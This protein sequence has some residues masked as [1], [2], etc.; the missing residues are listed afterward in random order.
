MRLNGHHFCTHLFLHVGTLH[1]G[2]GD[3]QGCQLPLCAVKGSRKRWL[4]KWRPLRFHCLLAPN[5]WIRYWTQFCGGNLAV[6]SLNWRGVEFTIIIYNDW[7]Q[8]RSSNSGIYSWYWK[9]YWRCDAQEMRW[10]LLFS[11]L[12]F[13][14]ARHS[15]KK[16]TT[17][18][19][20]SRCLDTK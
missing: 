3:N 12:N 6:L 1:W 13:G 2:S 7:N 15:E 9:L 14:I 20:F 11:W 16:S 4:P 10:L 19:T 18:K 17:N 8:L 5:F